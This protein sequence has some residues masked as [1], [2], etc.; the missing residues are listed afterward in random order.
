MSLSRVRLC[1]GGLPASGALS[2]RDLDFVA[3]IPSPAAIRA[4]LLQASQQQQQSQSGSSKKEDGRATENDSDYE[5]DTD[6][7]ADADADDAAESGDDGIEADQAE[8]DDDESKPRVALTA[9][10]LVLVPL[11][12]PQLPPAASHAHGNHHHQH[13]SAVAGAGVR[14]ASSMVR[15][16][17]A[18]LV[19]AN[20]VPA[21][22]LKSNPDATQLRAQA[23]S[24]M[25]SGPRKLEA[26]NPWTCGAHVAEG[27]LTDKTSVVL[28]TVVPDDDAAVVDSAASATNVPFHSNFHQLDQFLLLALFARSQCLEHGT[29][30]PNVALLHGPHG[31]GKSVYL[32]NAA[33]SAGASFLKV[34]ASDLFISHPGAVERG[35]E[36]WMVLAQ[37]LRPCVLAIEDADVMFPQ[38]PAGSSTSD[39]LGGHRDGI[40]D[41]NDADA[42][43][44]A[45]DLSN[46]D[47]DMRLVYCAMSLFDAAAAA[48]AAASHTSP[49]GMTDDFGVAIV[50]VTSRGATSIHPLIRSRC[51]AEVS[52]PLPAAGFRL[53]LTS[54]LYHNLVSRLPW[55][56]PPP[57]V[58]PATQEH[59]LVS[60]LVDACQG[61]SG[62]DL[63]HLFAQVE[64]EAICHAAC[65]PDESS[66]SV[67]Q[68]LS[69]AAFAPHV[70]AARNRLTALASRTAH[71]DAVS[72]AVRWDDIGG[73]DLVKA[74][75]KE[76]VEGVY[77]HAR[78]YARLGISPVR[79][80]LLFGPPGT[81][82][83][84]LARAVATESHANFLSVS[85]PDLV[86]G[87]VGESER[88]LRRVFARAVRLAPCV[89]FIDEID[90]LFGTVL[91][92]Q[93]TQDANAAAPQHGFQ[94]PPRTA[95]I[96]NSNSTA[97]SSLEAA[98]PGMRFNFAPR[99]PREGTSTLSPANTI[100]PLAR[101]SA[102]IAPTPSF[103]R[104]A[105]SL[106]SALPVVSSEMVV[107]PSD[108]SSATAGHSTSAKLLAQLLASIDAAS[109]IDG[110]IILA[111]TNRPHVLDKSL[112]RSNRLESHLFVPPP[113]APER[114]SILRVRLFPGLDRAPL[115][116]ASVDLNWLQQVTE[117][118]TG[119]D[120]A[121]LVREAGVAAI[122]R[123]STSSALISAMSLQIG[124]GDFEQALL[125]VSPST[126]AG[127]LN[128]LKNWVHSL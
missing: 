81:G 41:E 126:N 86:K 54:H 5:S 121:N 61:F 95:T 15:V 110:I 65:C 82:K 27:M 6:D 12:S 58:V 67:S 37:K 73:L 2:T 124:R 96:P 14:V 72:T 16:A 17:D 3:A 115:A 91:D 46:A 74:R 62:G 13:Q 100:K 79:G 47:R 85:V 36:R 76:A 32:Q 51:D 28:S 111:A 116:D 30:A 20:L 69:K 55:P 64:L 84:L 113:T 10:Q 38:E 57:A 125:R 78:H 29:K 8:D 25:G 98:K 71:S 117:G 106:T 92:A 123:F 42:D 118:F 1:I 75:L 87:H 108:L 18:Q 7:H 80:V 21:A 89:V 66:P 104:P 59:D 99:Q 120:L 128:A 105:L 122:H 107:N 4:I 101:V 63:M 11:T 109:K 102:A 68:T 19:C 9:K 112:L 114:E 35:F 49:Q 56:S 24:Q 83:T 22:T 94:F 77:K 127:Q 34:R 88:T 33:A 43:D 39:S 50:L 44:S 53:Q 48:A 31:T 40:Q 52:I 97:A 70:T 45:S 119:A 60:Y 23:L 103:D 93:A 26:L 90:A